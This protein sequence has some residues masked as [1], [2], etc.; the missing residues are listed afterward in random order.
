[1]AELFLGWNREVIVGLSKHLT[2]TVF[3]AI[4]EFDVFASVSFHKEGF[5]CTRKVW[6]NQRRLAGLE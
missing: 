1:M 2:L 3:V 6:S 5:V 4:T